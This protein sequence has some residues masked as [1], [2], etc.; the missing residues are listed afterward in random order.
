[1]RR[2]IAPTFVIGLPGTEL[3]VG[4]SGSA[5]EWMSHGAVAGGTAPEGCDPDGP[6]YCHI[7]L[8][9]AQT[10]STALGDALAD[11][12]GQVMSCRYEVPQNGTLGLDF[13]K[14]RVTLTLSSGA[15]E[16]L[17]HDTSP[18]CN[19]GFR[20]SAEGRIISLCPGTC[21]RVRADPGSEIAFELGCRTL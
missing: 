8:S 17:M 4:S 20:Y 2:R 1:V 9:S 18:D 21:E 5:R 7:D 6:V 3:D 14:V 11:I 15:P 12:E 13:E 16:S 19:E 10:L